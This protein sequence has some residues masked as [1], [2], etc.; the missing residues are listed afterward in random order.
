MR[1]RGKSLALQRALSDFGAEKSFAQASRQL[2]EHYGVRLHRS[3]VREEV[4]KQAERAGGFV[5]REEGEAIASYEGQRSHRPG[6]PWLIV[7]TDGSMVR[8]G[9]LEPDPA[10]GVSVGGRPKRVRRT[11][12]REVRLS[13]VETLNGGERRY[14]AAIGPP[15][16]TGEQM[17]ALALQSG[18]GDDTWVHGV[19]DGAPPGRGRGQALDC[20]TGGV[21]LPQAA[22]SAGPLPSSGTPARGGVCP[23][24]G[25]RRS[26]QGLGRSAGEPH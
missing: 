17:F 13:L 3:S 15:Q 18:Y 9:K 22:L 20:V 12:W 25:R 8:T 4:L 14:A 16:R 23:V 26:G 19:G 21:S 7:E 6:P 24:A 11:Q 2:E 10:G 1:G 5:A